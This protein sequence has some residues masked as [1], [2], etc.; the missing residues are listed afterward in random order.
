MNFSFSESISPS[1][2]PTLPIVF[3]TP[4]EVDPNLT[5]FTRS[6]ANCDKTGTCYDGM[7]CKLFSF[8]FFCYQNHFHLFL[9]QQISSEVG[10]YS[11][12]ST[13]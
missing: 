12:N 6:D 1:E 3:D 8:N 9:Q 10:V 5:N 11:L 4:I 7:N 13:I 2:P